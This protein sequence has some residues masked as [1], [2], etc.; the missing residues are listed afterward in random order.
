LTERVGPYPGRRFT[1]QGGSGYGRL[2]H[3]GSRE[4]ILPHFREAASQPAQG[5]GWFVFDEPDFRSE[6]GR[7]TP[8]LGQ[9]KSIHFTHSVRELLG[10]LVYDIAFND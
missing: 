7:A 10:V 9:E 4:F 2:G 5:I 6:L 1:A 8:F 3:F